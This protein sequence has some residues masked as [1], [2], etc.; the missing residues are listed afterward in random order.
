[1]R[2]DTPRNVAASV[3]DRLLQIARTQQEELQSLLTRYAI[4]RFLYRLSQTEHRQHFILKGANVFALWLGATHRPTRDVDFLGYGSDEVESIVEAFQAVCCQPVEE[5]GLV[6]DAEIVKGA[7]IRENAPYA[8]IR[9]TLRGTLGKATIPMQIDIGFGDVVTPAA[10]EAELPTLLDGPPA[11]LLTYP[12]ETVIA[13]KCEAMV[14][15]GLGNTRMKDF[16]DLWFLATHFDFEGPL[17][18]QAIAATF[19]RRGTI[20][21][22]LPPLALT[23]A[24]YEDASRQRQWKSFQVRS[25]VPTQADLSLEECVAVLRA[26]LL[27]LFQAVQDQVSLSR[28]WRHP[29]CSWGA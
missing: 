29:I 28:S 6:F 5:D 14:D 4:E 11:R 1:M 15:L 24:F 9:I 8:G 26:F 20:V 27:P 25:G 3:K 21:P 13:E 7:A 10:Q 19:R 18:C 2:Q 23:A 16:Y 17:L 12:R 22:P